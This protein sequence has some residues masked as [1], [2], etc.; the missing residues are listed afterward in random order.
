[1]M[2][3]ATSTVD[4]TTSWCSLPSPTFSSPSLCSYVPHHS[5]SEACGEKRQSFCNLSTLQEI[6]TRTFRRDPPDAVVDHLDDGVDAT[7]NPSLPPTTLEGNTATFNYQSELAAITAAIDRMRQRD[8]ELEMPPTSQPIP[9]PE[10]PLLHPAPSAETAT[11]ENVTPTAPMLSTTTA[12]PTMPDS[13]IVV[14]HDDDGTLHDANCQPSSI[15]ALF[16]AQAKMLHTINMLLVELDEL[17]DKLVDNPTSC[18]KRPLPS[19]LYDLLKATPYPTICL[20]MAI[21]PPDHFTKPPIP[22]WLPHTAAS[23]PTLAPVKKISPYKRQI[24]AKPP[25][26]G[27]HGCS[28]DRTM[29]MPRTKDGMRPP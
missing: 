23:G 20:T 24:P 29:A 14:A 22:P 25:F 27:H 18:D 2:T 8:A 21:R 6:P 10:T 7:N 19:S 28:R 1:M 3:M 13:A 9:P 5:K 16:V 15:T 26:P 11:T 4:R 12:T 17:V